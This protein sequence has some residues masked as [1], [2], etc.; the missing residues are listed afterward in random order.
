MY[1]LRCTVRSVAD[2]KLFYSDP[3][4]TLRVITDLG[5]SILSKNRTFYVENGVFVTAFFISIGLPQ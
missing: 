5:T 1:I 2:P 4:S 3:D